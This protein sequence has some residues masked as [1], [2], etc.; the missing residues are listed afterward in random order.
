MAEYSTIEC[1]EDV[2]SLNDNRT[3]ESWNPTVRLVTPWAKRYQLRDDILGNR[4]T[5][6]H[7]TGTN[8][9]RA[10]SAVIQP[11]GVTGTVI[12]G[13]EQLLDYEKAI[14]TVGYRPQNAMG[15]IPQVS[16]PEG[17]GTVN[18]YELYTES[19]ESFVEYQAMDHKKLRWKS[20]QK[21]LV[22]KQAP[23]LERQRFKIQ[24]TYFGII[25]APTEILTLQ[26]YVNDT[27]L[28]QPFYIIP[29]D[30]PVETIQYKGPSRLDLVVRTDGIQATNLTLNF[31][32]KIEGWNKFWRNFNDGS[33]DPAY[34]EIEDQNSKT[35]KPFKPADLSTV[36]I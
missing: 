15:T 29:F 4:R 19:L 32:A 21:A 35:I 28:T 9:P 22:A 7:G 5:W 3:L 11:F 23:G 26:D 14:V 27:A 12:S 6:P 13:S 10:F 8:K 33:T 25:S 24:R 20:D 31:S 34:D 17:G 18:Q 2:G 1:Y 16:N 30:F 36:L